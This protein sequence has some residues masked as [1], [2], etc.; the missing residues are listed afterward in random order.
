MLTT[1]VGRNS[2][3]TAVSFNPDNPELLEGLVAEQ[4]LTEPDTHDARGDIF[5]EVFH[6]ATTLSLRRQLMKYLSRTWTGA[7]HAHTLT[8]IWGN[9]V[10]GCHGM[11]EGFAACGCPHNPNSIAFR[12][13]PIRLPDAPLL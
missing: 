3:S 11:E 12:R 7:H 9:P 1:S 13:P 5:C 6:A 2:T 10:V 4:C 8:V